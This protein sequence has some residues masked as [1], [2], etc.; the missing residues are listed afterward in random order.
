MRQSR[1]HKRIKPSFSQSMTSQPLGV[2]DANRGGEVIV[3]E[4]ENIKQK[5]LSVKGQGI[6]ERRTTKAY[7]RWEES[8]HNESLGLLV[9]ELEDD[10]HSPA[11]ERKSIKVEAE[12]V[13]LGAGQKRR[14]PSQARRMRVRV[15]ARHHAVEATHNNSSSVYR[16]TP[17]HHQGRVPAVN[18]QPPGLFQY[19]DQEYGRQQQ[20]HLHVKTSMENGYDSSKTLTMISRTPKVRAAR[21]ALKVENDQTRRQQKLHQ[22]H[23][24]EKSGR[25]HQTVHRNIHR[26]ACVITKKAHIEFMKEETSLRNG[27]AGGLMLSPRV[28]EGYVGRFWDVLGTRDYMRARFNFVDRIL[29]N[30]PHH[31]VAVQTALD[32]LMDMLRLNRRDSMGLRDMVPSLMLRL[33]RN[34]DAY[35]F[36][37]WWAVFPGRY[38]WSDMALPY[39]DTKDVDVLEN[40]S[41]WAGGYLNFSH[42]AAVILIKLRF[43]SNLRDLQNTARAFQASTLPCQVVNQVRGN[44]LDDSLLVGRQDLAAADTVTLAAMIERVRK[45]V[46]ELYLAVEEANMHFWGRLISMQDDG[47]GLQKPESYFRGSPEEADLIALRN[48][49]A[50]EE[51]PKALDEIDAVWLLHLDMVA[52]AHEDASPDEEDDFFDDEE[53][54]VVYDFSYD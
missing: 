19:A 20:H 10:G 37:K 52:A 12:L 45:Q 28:F 40:P 53:G 13:R 21:P 54:G 47:D 33:G 29:S 41:W 16:P 34:Q 15:S 2:D 30:F 38:D 22:A 49:A 11:Y 8:R 51:T 3:P 35:D 1:V 23:S 42:A 44:L 39:L 5:W 17:H 50:W 18:D 6:G 26:H 14:K 36:V 32:H 27:P 43:L 46:W 48:Y 7:G 24:G 9:E 31:Q 25:D 4:E